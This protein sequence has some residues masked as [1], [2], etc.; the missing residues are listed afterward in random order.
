VVQIIKEEVAPHQ[1]VVID[2]DGHRVKLKVRWKPVDGLLQTALKRVW[3]TGPS[4]VVLVLRAAE[5]WLSVQD[6][7]DAEASQE[8]PLSR[9]PGL[10]EDEL[11][12]L[13]APLLEERYGG[14]L[15]DDDEPSP[16]CESS[17][18]DPRMN[19]ETAMGDYSVWLLD[20]AR[21]VLAVVDTWATVFAKM[22]S[23]DL[24]DAIERDGRQL[25]RL[26]REEISAG[27]RRT[28]ALIVAC[29]ELH[30]RLR[31]SP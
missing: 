22:R 20:E 23:T 1:I 7:R 24:R 31:S 6:L 26:W 10:D 14:K 8:H 29:D 27:G 19:A 4:V 2:V 15:I 25:L 21:R 9:P 30:A 12:R 16:R 3:K 28:G 18:D 11:K 17:S 5:H 13:R